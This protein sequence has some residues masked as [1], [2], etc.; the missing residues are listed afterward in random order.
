ME[1]DELKASKR[2]MEARLLKP[3]EVTEWK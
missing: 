1:E 2:R 3:E